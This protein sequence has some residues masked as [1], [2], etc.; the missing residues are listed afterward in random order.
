MYVDPKKIQGR[1]VVVY[2]SDLQW[3]QI[4]TRELH[5]VGFENVVQVSAPKDALQA[6]HDSKADAI[7]SQHDLTLIRFLRTHEASPNRDIAI[8][9]VTTELNAEDI[10]AERD[11]GVTEI[12][13]KPASVER[14]VTHLYEALTHPRDF[15]EAEVYHGPDR[16]RH[17]RQYDKPERRG[18]GKA[19]VSDET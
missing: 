6:I 7:V 3:R 18:G 1:T 11:A 8:I 2:D 10:L 9:L 5:A 4:L 13:A 17:L 15:I 12:V 19:E 16:R 14:V